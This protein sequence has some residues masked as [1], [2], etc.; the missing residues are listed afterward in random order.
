MNVFSHERARRLLHARS[1]DLSS[2]QR[3]DLAD[4][5]AGCVECRAYAGDL[6]TLQP[7]L[8]KAMHTRWDSR[9][10]SSAPSRAIQ[11][12]WEYARRKQQTVRLFAVLAAIGAVILLI[13]TARRCSRRLL[14]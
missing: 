8:A 4:H 9:R 11:Q 3:A 6:R 14:A 7:A 12:R 5:L 10:P 1:A 13:F 2:D